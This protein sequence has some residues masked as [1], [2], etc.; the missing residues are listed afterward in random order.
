MPIPLSPDETWEYQLVEDRIPDKATG[1]LDETCKPDKTKAFFKF[2]APTPSED[3]RIEDDFTRVELD[4][5]SG[6]RVRTADL[7]SRRNEVLRVQLVGWRNFPP[8]FKTT[9]GHNGR[10]YCN[11]D[12]SLAYLTSAQLYELAGAA[13]QRT[14]VTVDESD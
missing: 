4:K 13:L 11:V 10:V 14:R 8:E 3:A 12:Y 6:D 1:R 2:R 7:G 5:R 9:P